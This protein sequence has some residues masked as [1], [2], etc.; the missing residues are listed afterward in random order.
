M[1]K[2]T[3]L[4]TVGGQHIK[5]KETT[6]EQTDTKLTTEKHK[7]FHNGHKNLEFHIVGYIQDCEMEKV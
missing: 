1:K 4:I 7:Q 3:I 5:S 2:V 6:G